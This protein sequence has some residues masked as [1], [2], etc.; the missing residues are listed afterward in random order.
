KAM[1]NR[2]GNVTVLDWY[3]I[4]EQHPEYLYSDKIH[5]NPEGQAVYADLIMQAIGK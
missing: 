1:P 3:T 4:A 5:L 2:Y